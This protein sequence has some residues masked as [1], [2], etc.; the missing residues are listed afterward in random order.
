MTIAGAVLSTFIWNA[1]FPESAALS[2]GVTE[3][4]SWPV[5]ALL[6]SMKSVIHVASLAPEEE[7]VKVPHFS[8][9]VISRSPIFKDVASFATTCSSSFL[10][11]TVIPA[12]PLA[13]FAVKYNF[14][15]FL[16]SPPALKLAFNVAFDVGFSLV[17]RAKSFPLPS[18]A[19]AES[20][21]A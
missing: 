2:Y 18:F 3:T 7:D 15:N 12:I 21:L 11:S 8:Q 16:S 20:L 17:V 1:P 6:R 5:P 10:S 13:S 9:P 4:E 19:T 14:T